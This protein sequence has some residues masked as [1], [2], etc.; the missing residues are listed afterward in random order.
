MRLIVYEGY[1]EELSPTTGEP[2]G[3]TCA[4]GELVGTPS[5]LAALM[6]SGL[7]EDEA[8]EHVANKSLPVGTKYEIAD[9]GELPL[10]EFRNAWVY[11][12]GPDEKVSVEFIQP[13]PDED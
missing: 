5:F 1:E 3:E 6:N 4:C 7:T 9:T 2:T 11:A 8:W 13:T 12:S 10:N